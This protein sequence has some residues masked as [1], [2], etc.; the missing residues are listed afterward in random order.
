[1]PITEGNSPVKDP[2]PPPGN[3][4]VRRLAATLLCGLLVATTAACSGDDDPAPAPA[5]QDTPTPSEGSTSTL[6]AKPVP[7]EVRVTRVAGRM[8]P[9]DQDVLAARIGAVVSSY[10]EDAFLGGEYPRTDFDGAFA[11]FTG[12]AADQAQRDRDL[13]TN[14]ALGPTT[15]SVVARRQTAYLSVL[16][17]HRVAAGVTARVHLRFVADR[18]DEPDQEVTV[19]GR[20]MLTRTND[21]D[22][23]IFGYDLTQS[24][25]TVEEGS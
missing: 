1:M 6:E 23:T 19:K 16:A 2:F 20:L 3:G 14:A 12:G 22:W 25:S 17:P 10:F 13:L 11:T 8:R 7:A 5:V 18:G 24:A 9:K 4:P 15:E 21:G